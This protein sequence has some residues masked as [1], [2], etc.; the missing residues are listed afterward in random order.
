MIPILLLKGDVAVTEPR[1]A[2]R[3]ISIAFE[4]NALFINFIS[5]IKGVQ[6]DNA[7]DLDVVIPMYNLLEYSKNYRKRA[8]SLWNYYTK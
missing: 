5:K 6:I 7:E 4:N 1:N 3:N 8:G 2:K